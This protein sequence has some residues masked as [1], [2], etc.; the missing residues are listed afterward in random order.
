MHAGFTY[1]IVDLKEKINKRYI[2]DV[3]Q[4]FLF[5]EIENLA[6]NLLIQFEQQY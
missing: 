4:S 5:Y 6:H 2:R 3:K 1:L